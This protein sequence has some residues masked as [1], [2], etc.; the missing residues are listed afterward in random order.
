M[1]RTR[2]AVA[3]L[4]VIFVCANYALAQTT[5]TSTEADP[6]GVHISVV[7]QSSASFRLQISITN[8]TNRILVHA[9]P[10]TDGSVQIQVHDQAGVTPPET[11]FGCKLHVSTRC[12]PSVNLHRPVSFT[13]TVV[14]LGQTVSFERDLSKEFNLVTVESVVVEAIAR[15]FVLVD[16]PQ[17]VGEAPP[18]VR[19]AYLV[20]Y[21]Q[22][23]YTK[24]ASFRSKAI[25]VK[26]RH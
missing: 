7:E 6:V 18:D 4:G 23:P 14:M 8:R 12:G 5:Q 26:V 24:L 21:Q 16:A 2:G 15:D 25:T 22:Y 10:D 1:R 20:G 19:R 9:F 13:V 17:N 3:L 11:V